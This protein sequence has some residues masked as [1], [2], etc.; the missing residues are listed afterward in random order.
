MRAR[1]SSDLK[2]AMK[3]GEK[4]KVGTLRLINAAIQTA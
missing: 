3:A 4:S 1:I 2:S